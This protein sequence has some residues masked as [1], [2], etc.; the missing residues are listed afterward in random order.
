VLGI[1]PEFERLI[2]QSIGAGAIAQD[3]LIE[4]SLARMFGEEVIQGVQDMESQN[5]APVIVS[6]TRT[7]MTISRIARRVCPQAVVLALSEL[8]PTANLTFYKVLCSQAGK[9]P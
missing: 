5:L 9:N 4:P 1:Q 7:R 3:G 2:E 6:G 8:P